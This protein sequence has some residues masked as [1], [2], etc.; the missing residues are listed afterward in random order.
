MIMGPSCGMVL[1]DL[2][3]DVIKI[4]PSPDGDNTR[5]LLG[6]A[7]G[8]FPSFNRNKRSLCVDL[9]SKDGLALV[10]KLAAS[11]DVVLENFRPGAMDKLGLGPAALIEA[12]P[13]LIYCSCKGF[14]PGPYEHRAALDE[15]V[16]MMGGL[17]YMTSPPCASARRPARAAMCSPACSRPTRC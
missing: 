7:I 8:F 9:K 6:S 17:A 16:Q 12:N 3:A 15:V 10:K 13:R 5:R 4:E 1:G 2:G 14:L 11:A